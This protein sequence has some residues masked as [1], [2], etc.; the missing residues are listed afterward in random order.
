[1]RWLSARWPTVDHHSFFRPA[2]GERSVVLDLGAST[3]SFSRTLI[4]LTGCRCHAVELL[5]EIAALIPPHRRLMVHCCAIGGTDGPVAITRAS[6]P[7]GSGALD[8]SGAAADTMESVSIPRFMEKTGGGV[9]DLMKIDIEAA[10]FD[11][12]DAVGDEA[13]ARIRQITVEFHDFMDPSL[14]PKAKA[15]IERLRRAGFRS[16]KFTRPY[17]GDVL[18]LRPELCSMAEFLFVKH[19][20]RN[21]RGIGRLIGRLTRPRA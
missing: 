16:I 14:T 11:A 3:A 10:E 2:I 6:S 9:V 5:P 15:A 19:V 17:H 1:M 8:R 21:A 20:L 13:L 4:S 12:L 7:D 18:F